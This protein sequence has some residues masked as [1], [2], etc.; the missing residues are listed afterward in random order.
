MMVEAGT[1]AFEILL[2]FFYL[3]GFLDRKEMSLRRLTLFFLPA[4][5]IHFCVSAFMVDYQFAMVI[6]YAVIS[7]VISLSLYTGRTYVRFFSPLL[8]SVIAIILELVSVLLLV[9]VLR[10]DDMDII[11]TNP[12]IKL[13]AIITKNLLAL[14]AIKSVIYFR[15]SHT[16]DIQTGYRLILLVV[17]AASLLICYVILDLVLKVPGG[18]NGLAL[19]GLLALL[20]VNVM[21]FVIFEGFMRQMGKE[22][23]YRLMEKQFDLQLNHYNQLAESRAHTREIWHDFR[24]HV[25]C[26]N[27][28]YQSGR[29]EALGKYLENLTH[30]SEIS[31]VVDTGNPVIDAILNNKES[32][33]K[34]NGIVF[35]MDLLIP[36]NLHLPPADA[37]A[38]FGNSLDNAIEACGRIKSPEVAR[39]IQLSLTYQNGYLVYVIANSIDQV[40]QMQGGRFKTWKPSPEF[41][42]LGLQSIERTVGQYSGNMVV[43]CENGLFRLEILLLVK[44]D[45]TQEERA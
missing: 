1:S 27:I 26:L 17:P 36:A 28:L 15:K 9:Q 18:N 25:N 10:I 8:L 11:R 29:T 5:A 34:Q 19:I 41:H 32:I 44:T 39:E 23:R 40:P 42:G 6:S 31:K 22:Y 45:T 7:V 43:K 38:I 3:N 30:Y 13:I 2:I 37:C 14:L 16:S 21:V 35:K 20:Y 33:A 12:Y 4:F 24:N